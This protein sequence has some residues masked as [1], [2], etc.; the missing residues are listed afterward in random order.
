MWG[1]VCTDV[2]ACTSEGEGPVLEHLDPVGEGERRGAAK[3]VS[4]DVEGLE[5]G[6]AAVIPW[7]CV[8]RGLE[9]SLLAQL[10]L[11]PARVSDRPPREA[12]VHLRS[13]RRAHCRLQ[14]V[15]RARAIQ[16]AELIA[17]AKAGPHVVEALGRRGQVLDVA[18]DII[19]V[20]GVL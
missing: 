9:G 20:A 16:R 7:V 19:G 3:R 10:G 6:D 5:A 12:A 4:C 1:C 18:D 8:A 17:A 14:R 2:G 15:E 13:E 11:H